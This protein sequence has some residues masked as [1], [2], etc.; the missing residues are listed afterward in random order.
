MQTG[1]LIPVDGSVSRE[2]K[3]A[4]AKFTLD[5]LQKAVGGYIEV[6]DIGEREEFSF[7]LNEEGK[8]EG[9]ADN[10][11]ATQIMRRWKPDSVFTISGERVV[12]PVLIV[13]QTLYQ[14]SAQT[15]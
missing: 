9:L 2:I 5:E 10:P 13:G 12:G 11:L 15:K 3:P 14:L 8:L 4:G 6:Y 1:L 7:Y